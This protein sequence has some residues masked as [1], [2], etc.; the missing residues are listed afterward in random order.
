MGGRQLGS[1]DQPQDGPG[2][3]WQAGST[4]CCEAW[5]PFIGSCRAHTPTLTSPN[6]T[7]A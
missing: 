4:W 6:L 1:A 3:A 5:C 7:A 2:T